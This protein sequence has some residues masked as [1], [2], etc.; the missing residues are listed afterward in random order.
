MAAKKELWPGAGLRLDF[1]N[2]ADRDRDKVERRLGEI[3]EL[4]AQ[5]VFLERLLATY[6]H[7][8]IEIFEDLE[9]QVAQRRHEWVVKGRTSESAAAHARVHRDEFVARGARFETYVR[10]K[11]KYLSEMLKIESKDH[12]AGQPAQVIEDEDGAE[13]DNSTKALALYALLRFAGLPKG[14]NQTAVAKFAR[15]MTG[16]SQRNMENAIRNADSASFTGEDTEAV[17]EQFDNMGLP[18][19]A[20][21][22]RRKFYKIGTGY[23]TRTKAR[24]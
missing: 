16:R 22:V 3:G 21:E 20:V 18:E 10:E 1:R 24:S 12:L 2:I 13:W 14:F 15:L 7:A 19:I 11:M 23:R 8:L 6:E 17:A 5:I 4:K 9:K